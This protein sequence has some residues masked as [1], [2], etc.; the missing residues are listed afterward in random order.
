MKH[1]ILN[2]TII[3]LLLP[4]MMGAGCEDD[5]QIEDFEV[6]EFLKFSD[7]GCENHTWN[8]KPGNNNNYYI[9]ES[10]DELIKYIQG[11][12]M[13]QID[14]NKYFV[15]IGSKSFTTGASLFAEKV[16]ENN[17]EIVYTVTFQ[18]DFSRVIGGVKYHVV[19]KK[20]N[21]KKD[22]KVIEVVKDHI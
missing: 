13:P 1:E 21:S 19:L 2:I 14:F 8:L 10:Q 11:E 6:K 22:I 3:L 12:C 5:I 18:T 20:A 7:F 15:I 17:V 4:I 16:E 9:I